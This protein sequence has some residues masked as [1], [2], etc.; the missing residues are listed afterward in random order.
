M[1]AGTGKQEAYQMEI[2]SQAGYS[3]LTD[4]I[5][6]VLEAGVEDPQNTGFLTINQIYGQVQTRVAEF[7]ASQNKRMEPRLWSL[8]RGSGEVGGTFVFI[9]EKAKDPKAPV[10]NHGDVLTKSSNP[11]DVP[12]PAA[13]KPTAT[14]SADRDTIKPGESVKLTWTTTDAINMTITPDIGSVTAQGTT[15]VTPLSSTTYTLTGTGPG[16]SSEAIVHIVVNNIAPAPYKPAE[17]PWGFTIS[18]GGTTELVE[19]VTAGLERQMEDR[20]RVDFHASPDQT[21][22]FHPRRLLRIVDASFQPGN[23]TGCYDGLI[24]TLK[25]T[26]EDTTLAQPTS[27]PL[28]ETK[29]IDCNGRDRDEIEINAIRKTVSKARTEISR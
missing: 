26:L 20:I 18:R 9:N 1:T 17:A 25:Y 11:G 27:E 28:R 29:E 14:L 4:A 2:N 7:E 23:S 13:V 8:E 21:H 6:K 24:F 16:G 10:T 15:K 22:D 5:L 3:V 12:P 19:L